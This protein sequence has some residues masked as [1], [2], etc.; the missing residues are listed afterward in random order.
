VA[1]PQAQLPVARYLGALGAVL[2]ILYALAFLTGNTHR[3]KLGLDLQGGTQVTLAAKTDNG[4]PPSPEAMN[5]AREILLQRVNGAGV[6]SAEVV[7]QGNSNLIISVTGE[8]ADKAKDLA[9]TAQLLFRPVIN[10]FPVTPAAAPSATAGG[11]APP[12]GSAVPS[13][14]AS[15][16]ASA[17]AGASPSATATP[18]ANGRAVPPLALAPTGTATPKPSA[19]PKA[20]ATTKAPATPA[21]S[22]TA[23]AGQQFPGATPEQA[24]M[25]AA[26]DCNSSETAASDP[27]KQIAACDRDG[28]TKYLLDKALFKGTEIA[29]A[30]AQSPDANSGRFEWTVLIN[31]KSAGQAVWSK[32][33]QAHNEQT[34]PNGAGNAVA[35]TLDDKVISA[36][37]IQVPIPGAT[38]VSGSFTQ[39]SAT[40]LADKLKYGAL[41]LSFTQEQALT[42]S[43]SLGTDQLKAGLL[44]GGI[45]LVLVVLYSLVY[46][47]ALGLVTIA[48]LVVSAALTYALLIIL[49]RAIGFALTLAGVAGFIVAVGITADSFV[50][51][52][53]RLKDEVRD[54]RTARS[55]V[56]RAWIR[57]RRTILSADAV[58]FLAAAILYYLA[59]GEVKGFAFTLGLSTI[60]DLVVVFL[61][62]HPLIALL[63]R[64]A[65]FTS[66]RISGLGAV[67]KKKSL[68]PAAASS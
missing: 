52:F 16:S 51:F 9:Q 5:Q 61:F 34:T 18:S 47:R 19:T 68:T 60:L 12:S 59:A 35:F 3:P 54:G 13:G 30:A 8:N 20:P 40:D 66:P 22:G 17:S 56:P 44:A 50:I 1:A 39:D 31:L 29:S 46:Y 53:E 26:L 57:A 67:R 15:P 63:S 45:G 11:S 49:G 41:P 55:G 48:S 24:A 32:Y 28:K 36:P 42:I 64:S 2:A 14:S 23:P 37:T 6:A 38:T 27:N 21:P 58:S 65:T 4:Q 62:T 33:T 10:G 25:L 43:P 7:T